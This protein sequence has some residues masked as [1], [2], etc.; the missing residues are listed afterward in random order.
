[1]ADVYAPTHTFSYFTH[2]NVV[3]M[4]YISHAK[5]S[6]TFCYKLFSGSVKAFIHAILPN[7]YI[8]STSDAVNEISTILEQSGCASKIS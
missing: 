3:C 4:S 2:P 1:M 5:L 8:S 7:L 6:L